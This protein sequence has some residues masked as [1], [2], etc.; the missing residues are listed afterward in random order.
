MISACYFDKGDFAPLQQDALALEVAVRR[1]R[2][3]ALLLV[4][5]G[6]GGLQEGEYAAGYV[7]MRIREWF[8]R[9]FLRHIE[10]GHGRRRIERDCV[11]LLYDCNRYLQAY[12]K[13]KK[14][15]LGTTMTMVLL[16]GRRSVGL[17]GVLRPLAYLYFH[18]GDSRAYVLGRKCKRLTRDDSPGNNI[19]CR[20]IGSFPWQGVRK[21]AGYLRPGER[22]LVCSDGFWRKVMPE[23]FRES[24][25]SGR[26][27]WLSREE[28]MTEGQLE[29]RLCKLGQT[30]RERGERDNQ[31]AVA[32]GFS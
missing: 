28:S 30:C 3:A 32:A 19:L 26:T 4:C 1:G 14:I 23:E 6:I 11:G 27:K 25:G 13:E 16:Q 9:D 29:R 20:C 17:W 2:E 12:G 24:L 31:A 22:I 21:G 10:K 7:T 5:D 8:Y 15:G 18:V